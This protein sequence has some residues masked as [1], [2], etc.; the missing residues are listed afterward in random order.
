MKNIFAG[1]VK[2]DAWIRGCSA[3]YNLAN[4]EET[5]GAALHQRG[6]SVLSALTDKQQKTPAAPQHLLL[7][8]VERDIKQSQNQ[9]N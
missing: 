9:N 5:R 8:S 4:V 1:Y 7:P 6:P 3:I 2:I